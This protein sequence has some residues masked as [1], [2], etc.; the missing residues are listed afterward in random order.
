MKTKRYSKQPKLVKASKRMLDRALR[1][2]LAA[3]KVC[4][5]HREEAEKSARGF[6]DTACV[7]SRRARDAEAEVRRL[8]EILEG[9][10]RD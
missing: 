1:Q 7:A 6:F 3:F 9:M 2:Q 10:R 8:R 5:R 4:Q